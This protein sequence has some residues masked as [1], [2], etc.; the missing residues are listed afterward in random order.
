MKRTVLVAAVA[1]LGTALAPLPAS[2]ATVSAPYACTSPLGTQGVTIDATLTADPNPAA[3]G[4]PVGFRLQVTGLGLTSPLPVTSWSGTVTL[5]VAGAE[6]A[7]VDVTGGGGAIPANQPIGGALAGSW[8]PAVAGVDEVTGGAV[9]ITADVAL[10][11]AVALT[12]APVE[13]QPVGETLT[14]R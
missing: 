14:V 9:T 11:G 6:T 4:E 7:A 1:A 3:V 12:C 13:P 8:T 10:I 2:A 5:N